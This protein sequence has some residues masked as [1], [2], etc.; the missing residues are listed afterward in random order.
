MVTHAMTATNLAR[1]RNVCNFDVTQLP[2]RF[3]LWP[4]RI[5]TESFDKLRQEFQHEEWASN[6]VF[7]KMLAKIVADDIAS[8]HRSRK[9]EMRIQTSAGQQEGMQVDQPSGQIVK[10]NLGN[11]DDKEMNSL[12]EALS[13]VVLADA[14]RG[15]AFKTA[16][17][18]QETMR[19][20][21]PSG[22]IVKGNLGNTENKEM[23]SL[24]EALSLVVLADA[25]RGIA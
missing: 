7:N 13:L 6:H 15:I 9:R 19:V 21:Q 11:T 25:A 12:Q 14:D 22:Q 10:G 17:G 16:A 3:K 8:W 2:R 18:Q 4:L 23:N 24:Q 5:K 1:A 20:D